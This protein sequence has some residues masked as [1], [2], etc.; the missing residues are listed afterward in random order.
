MIKKLVIKDLFGIKKNNRTINFNEDL[1]ILVG[2]NGAGKTT[3]LGIL[4][5]LIYKQFEKLFNYSFSEL[6]LQTESSD[7][8]VFK[9]DNVL[10]INYIIY[11]DLG[12]I[13]KK[14]SESLSIEKVKD[15]KII[16]NGS[17][18]NFVAYDSKY[19]PTYRRLETDL[20]DLLTDADMREHNFRHIYPKRIFDDLLNGLSN[21]VNNSN[22]VLG[23]SNKDIN[24]IIDKK[25][26]EVTEFEKNELNKLIRNFI[27][28]LLSPANPSETKTSNINLLSESFNS[29]QVQKELERMFKKVGYIVGQDS[30]AISMIK[31]HVKQVEWAQEIFRNEKNNGKVE[32]DELGKTLEIFMSYTRIA[33]LLEMYRQTHDTISKKQKAFDELVTILEEFIEMKVSLTDGQLY[34]SK[35]GYNITFEQLSAGEKQLVAMFV[36][37][38]LSLGDN[39]IVIID[40]PELS[41]HIDWQRNFVRA[42][43]DGSQKLQYII[44]THSPF[45]ISGY[46]NKVSFLAEIGVEELHG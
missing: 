23:L 9:E 36:Y 14:L 12:E 26:N 24:R 3:I 45:I 7:L 18:E 35:E 41:L 27:F 42:L 11:N 19:F 6:T 37:T 44:S 22:M 46:K 34:F 1:T 28:S 5:S 21:G 38:K 16:T 39:G 29:A 40:E 8:K 13:D 17:L 31:E 20:L 4:N 30:P 2:K 43:T 10:E 32:M 25:W 33:Q 15:D